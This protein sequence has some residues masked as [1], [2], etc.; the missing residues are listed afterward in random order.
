[1][2]EKAPLAL[3]FPHFAASISHEFARKLVGLPSRRAKVATASRTVPNDRGPFRGMRGYAH[4]LPMA[5]VALAAS[6]LALAPTAAFANE[7]AYCVTC[8][9]PDQTYLCRVTGEDLRRND[10][11]KL[12]CVVRTAKEGGH[13]SCAARDDVS[14]CNGV[15]K[16][17]SYNGPNIPEGLADDPRVKKLMERVGHDQKDFRKDDKRKSLIEVT[18]EAMSASRRG[19]RNVRA[20]LGGR[21]AGANQSPLPVKPA[22]IDPLQE[23]TS[24]TSAPLPL[25]AASAPGA[26][27]AAMS[28]QITSAPPAPAR[29]SRVK[30]GAQSVGHF[31]RSSYRCVRSLFRECR[32]AEANQGPN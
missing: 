15:E 16:T 4:P 5:K 32:S 13:A 12:Y 19:L 6:L 23:L 26:R 18:G 25:S 1:M 31:A 7:A 2:R 22:P 11:L 9:G 29:T 14:G 24:Q 30:R 17:Y 3:D 27:T 21:A 28:P 20:S 8:Q 10:G